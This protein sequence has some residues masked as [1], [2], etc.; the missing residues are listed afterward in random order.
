[1]F[2]LCMMHNCCLCIQCFSYIYL[3]DIRYSNNERLQSD[4]DQTHI[5]VGS[6]Y[7]FVVITVIIIVIMVPI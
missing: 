6:F 5:I 1:M 3:Y 2:H 4:T 7:G